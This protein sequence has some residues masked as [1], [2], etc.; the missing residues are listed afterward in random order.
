[1]IDKDVVESK[2]VGLSQSG[3]AVE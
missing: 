3:N 2:V 1:M